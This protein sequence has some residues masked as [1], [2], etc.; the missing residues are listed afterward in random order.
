MKHTELLSP[1][2]SER[3]SLKNKMVM[4]PLTRSRSTQEHIPTDIMAKYYG[5]R[6]TAGLIITEGTA[7]SPNGVGYPRIPGIYNDHQVEAWK[8]VTNS[9]H[10]NDARIFMQLMHTGRVSH[11]DNMPEG[12]IIFAPSAIKPES[13]KMYVDGK[14]ELEIP[15]PTAMSI[16][17][18]E[19]VIKEYVTAAKNAIEAGFNGVEVHSANGYLLDQFLNP[20][21]NKRTDNYG[22][23]VENRCRLTLEV[24][25]HVAN[26]IGVDKV[27]IRISPNGAM[28]DIG[29][30]EGQEETFSYLTSKINNIGILYMHLVD[31]EAMG[32]PALPTD[33]R[34]NIRD[35]FNGLLILSGGYDA[36]SGNQDLMD[37]KGDLIAY[38][39]DFLANPDLP[40]RFEKEA[41]LNEPD[42]ETFYSPGP[43]GYI[44]YPTLTEST[45][46]A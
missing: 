32:A 27:G 7:P 42:Q 33:I 41:P 45:E 18:I 26:A 20:K 29:P 3:I 10:K 12:S 14:G 5:E 1:L 2:N 9:V 6:A 8:A 39:R 22:G 19:T 21:T 25:Q 24:T 13:T 38:G 30:F 11:P 17:D 44:D 31:H 43:K 46:L 28:N 16:S 4:A 23:S 15:E 37:N 35:T 36:K 40:Q 34:K